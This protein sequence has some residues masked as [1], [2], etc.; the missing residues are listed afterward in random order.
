MA[1]TGWR[2]TGGA[3]K[4]GSSGSSG[5]SGKDRSWRDASNTGW[6]TKAASGKPRSRIFSRAVGVLIVSLLLGVGAW[7]LTLPG[8]TPTYLIVATAK[9]Y[10]ETALP[11]NAF[12][13]ND[14]AALRSLINPG[15]FSGPEERVVT[16]FEEMVGHAKGHKNVVLYLNKLGVRKAKHAY[17]LDVQA[18]HEKDAGFV[19]LDDLWKA[20][21]E[22]PENN[23][24]VKVVLLDVCRFESDWRLGILEN[25]V[26]DNLADNIAD[27]DNLVVI[28]SCAPGEVS[29]TSAHLGGGQ[30]VFGHYAF[31]ALAGDA[32]RDG[33]RRVSIRE[34]YEFVHVKS[35]NWVNLNRDRAGQHPQIFLSDDSLMEHELA[36]VGT[37]QA[38]EGNVKPTPIASMS[39]K[40]QE[41]WILRDKL[42]DDSRKN[43]W[44]SVI[45]RHPLAWR[46]L[47]FDLMRAEELLWSR[48]VKLADAL[49]KDADKTLVEL[50]NDFEHPVHGEPEDVLDRRD[51]F[52]HNNVIRR[53]VSEDA[54]EPDP[55]LA[56]NQPKMPEDHLTAMFSATDLLPN[57]VA[58]LP[59]VVD[60]AIKTRKLAEQ[61]ANQSLYGLAW[62]RTLILDADKSRRMGEDDLFAGRVSD[63]STHI[64]AAR[65][66]YDA[67]IQVSNAVHEAQVTLNQLLLELPDLAFWASE[68]WVN[69]ENN[70]SVQ[71]WGKSGR[72]EIIER[73]EE[74]L[75]GAIPVDE[76]LENWQLPSAE[77][78]GKIVP[79]DEL[80]RI[81]L[82]TLQLFA[83]AASL[84]NRLSVVKTLKFPLGEDHAWIDDLRRDAKL[85][86][87][88]FIDIDERVCNAARMFLD[89]KHSDQFQQDSWRRSH[90]F[91]QYS[92]LP[93]EL[94]QK[95][96]VARAGFETRMNE[97]ALKAEVDN[98]KEV[99]PAPMATKRTQW[100]ALWINHVLTLGMHGT[101]QS[102]KLWEG[103][104]FVAEAEDHSEKQREKLLNLGLL[105]R[106]AW[107]E[108]R[109]Q[110]RVLTRRPGKSVAKKR[111]DLGEADR[112]ARTL[113]GYDAKL[114]KTF[115]EPAAALNKLMMAELLT[116]HSQ[117]FAEDFWASLDQQPH[118]FELAA[119]QSLEAARSL[120]RSLPTE[121]PADMLRTEFADADRLLAA[122]IDAHLKGSAFPVVFGL[123]GA[124]RLNLTLIEQGDVPD[125][126][127]AV[128]LDKNSVKLNEKFGKQL[129][130]VDQGRV[131]VETSGGDALFTLRK[132][133]GFDDRPGCETLNVKLNVAFRGH[134]WKRSVP[135]VSVDPCRQEGVA[136]HWKP[137]DTS[138]EIIV[139]G[140]DR[141]SVMFILDC[142]NSMVSK[143]D[144]LRFSNAV[145]TLRDALQA[146]HQ[147]H[148]MGG[149]ENRREVGLTVY[150]HRVQQLSQGG[151]LG[152][153]V[154]R[155]DLPKRFLPIP[156]D[157]K[158]PYLDIQRLRTVQALTNA[159]FKDILEDLPLLSGWGNT[160]LIG[161]IQQV[162]K[163][164][165]PSGGTIVAI[166]DGADT[167]DGND[168]VNLA[169]RV[170]VL[171]NDARNHPKGV[172][173]SIVG[174]AVTAADRSKLDALAKETGGAF[175][176]APTG[177]QLA[178]A[179]GTAL[180][181]RPYVVTSENPGF[182][183]KSKLGKPQPL[184]RGDY[185]VGFS[186]LQPLG[187]EMVGGERLAYAL[188]RGSLHHQ[189]DKTIPLIKD[190][191]PA[192]IPG[193]P[194]ADHPVSFAYRSF[195][196]DAHKNQADRATATFLF[197]VTHKNPSLFVRR[198]REIF[199]DVHPVT[200]RS[201]APKK[202]RQME[203]HLQPGQSIPTWKV[204]VHD[205]PAGAAAEVNAW[206]K[207]QR[208]PLDVETLPLTS[209]QGQ[210]Q[211]TTDLSL[212]LA[213]KPN[214]NIHGRTVTIIVKAR[215]EA[216]VSANDALLSELTNLR[217]ELGTRSSDKQFNPHR[218]AFTRIFRPDER[219]L[220]FRFA[221]DEGFDPSKCIIGVTTWKALR[222]NATSLEKPLVI[223]KHDRA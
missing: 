28:T 137:A 57:D 70:R 207:M 53:L 138:G 56:D 179:L 35:L 87:E 92:L 135:T 189:K 45:E 152:P 42:R 55:N 2:G 105:I 48:E 6:D 64:K 181:S 188:E 100:R 63:A 14:D 223:P 111:A 127:A 202:L 26:L 82:A 25:S 89:Q 122:R 29:Y 190:S 67:G 156:A 176:D 18:K 81:E 117:R 88:K 142:S 104:Q 119:K 222:T 43:V 168:A 148:L 187:F 76:G 206:W 132:P 194:A 115:D 131:S 114:L 125:G 9:Q 177:K 208:S 195:E 209:E 73:H 62:S 110:P 99:K 84:A 90:E 108:K 72:S 78:L 30:S 161:S 12:A 203:W 13:S 197:S 37:H 144:P 123:E 163:Q 31:R 113:H 165:I 120:A 39:D 133:P 213:E 205:W 109:E 66:R 173:I 15:H 40:L 217:L 162:V 159:H 52:A 79:D 157:G 151:V 36:A 174:F 155:P 65:A 185:S 86:R 91:L 98:W 210:F 1:N 54:A 136:F 169:K 94:R 50:Q 130:I 220:E 33:N 61:S 16:T 107:I 24:Q 219:S 196:E 175:F 69:G 214:I 149:D 74:I 134:R 164:Y 200:A 17:V 191:V 95:L 68:R 59:D 140:A 21:K 215:G 118:W 22:L 221:V 182:T 218:F 32:D 85:A 58:G 160:P 11:P 19:Q 143:E 126:Q 167:Q 145:N 184:K 77:Q 171:K 47:T 154:V 183:A 216:S 212:D 141:R 38:T 4:G 158:Q 204:I 186:D 46:R 34:L 20:L 83:E 116:F 96:R 139:T 101:P 150:G 180:T 192:A 3:S 49:I 201:D 27:I 75:S 124:R 211:L 23:E 80:V 147:Q 102:K 193:Q 153:I 93:S 121:F 128:W 97:N 170:E 51:T 129:T 112:I 178:A 44:S 166:T 199:F 71:N 7:M 60:L 198:P 8:C 41:R 10:Q 103:W 106:Q 172:E 5:G 146:L